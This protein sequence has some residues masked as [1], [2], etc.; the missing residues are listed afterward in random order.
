MNIY[1]DVPVG[2]IQIYSIGG[3]LLGSYSET[4]IDVSNLVSGIYFLTI[5]INGRVIIKKFVK[6]I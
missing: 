5:E 4:Q 1:T 3:Q 6:A 2:N